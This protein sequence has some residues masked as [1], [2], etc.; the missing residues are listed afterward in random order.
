M[1]DNI[2]T[3]ADTTQSKRVLTAKV[4]GVGDAG[5]NALAHIQASG[6]AGMTFV[7]LN[8]DSQ[9]LESCPV[10][11]K[12]ELGVCVTR[13]LGAGGDPDTGR[14]AAAAE[15]GRLKELCAGTDLV[16]LVA[17]LG[18]GTGTGASAV[19]ARAAKEAGALVIALVALPFTCE[20]TR[21]SRQAESGVR[22]LKTAADVVICLPNRKLEGLMD[23][24]ASLRGSFKISNE[25]LAQ[26]MRGLWQMITRPGL[27]GIGFS[28]LCNAVRGRHT[29]SVFAFAEAAGNGRACEAVEKLLAS[30][31]L[32]EGKALREAD[33]IL[34]SLVSGNDPGMAEINLVMTEIN[35]HV[36]GV[37]VVMGAAIDEALG[38]RLSITLIA[39]RRQVTTP[40]ILELP[41]RNETPS[42]DQLPAAG[43]DGLESDTNFFHAAPVERSGSRHVPPAPEMTADQKQEL[44]ERQKPRGDVAGFMKKGGKWKQGV[45]PLEVV[46]KGRFEKTEKNVHQGE[47]LDVPTYIRRGLVLN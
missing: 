35:R 36:E 45:L 30:P 7:A 38:D 29:E 8:T 40:A 37:D 42:A 18:R 10:A 6:L 14:A 27:L 5:C 21:L 25:W 19:V 26:G 20:G 33:S 9:A 32:E 41:A 17:G 12:L 23:P 28:S 16:F 39:T 3:V 1:T 4:L 31:M 43:L 15:V 44:L 47:D 11:E 46:S 24:G 34:V 13:G 22:E 2:E